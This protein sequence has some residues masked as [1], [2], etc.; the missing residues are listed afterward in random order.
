MTV[1]P[2]PPKRLLHE[3]AKP[4]VRFS[5]NEERILEKWDAERTFEKSLAASASQQPYSFYDGPPFATGLPHYGNLLAGVLKD[6]VPRYWTMRGFHVTRRFGW[7]CHGLPVEYE[8]SKKLKIESNKQILEMGIERY[9]AECRGIVQRYTQ[10][11]KTSVRRIGRWVDM[12]NPYFTMD[13]SF[14]ESVWWVFRQLWDK[15]LVYEG[16]KVLPYSTGVSTPL[17]NFEANLNYK[18]VQDPAV[19]VAFHTT[20]GAFALL[21]WTTTPWTLPSNLALAVHRDLSY[22]K[23]RDKASGKVYVLASAL[24]EKYFAADA[25]ETLATLTGADLLGTTYRPLFPYFASTPNAFRVIH[26][27]HVT[28]EAGTGLVHMAPAFGEED[29]VA[30][31]KHGI[32]IVNPVD[33]DGMFTAEVPDFV[34][35]RVKDA[36]R[37]IIQKLKEQG[38]LIRHETITHSYPFCWRSNTPLI[39]RAV[40]TWFIRVEAVKEQILAGNRETTWV[41][42][43]LRDGRFGKWLENARDWAVSRNRFWGTPLP[44]WRNDQGETLCIGSI[45]ELEKRTGQRVT[46]LHLDAVAKLEIPSATGGSPLRQYGGVLDCWFESGSMPYAQWGYPKTNKAEFE[47]SFPADFIAEGLDQTRGWFYT[48]TVIGNAL[49]GKSPFKNVVVNGLL[50]AEDGKKMSKSLRNYPDPQVLF[51]EHGAD[52]LR[53]YLVDSPAVKAQEVQFSEKGVRDVVRKILLRWWNAYSFYISY[54]NIEA[55]EPRGPVERSPNV[56]D[57]WILSRLN[58][59]IENTNREMEAYK[60]YNVVPNLLA[61]IEDLT[62]TYIRFNRKHFWADGMP[63]DKRQAFETLFHVLHTLAKVMAPFTPFLSEVT[64]GNL[65]RVL[66][67]PKESVHL[68]MYP[69]ADASRIDRSLEDAVARMS[70]M[71]VMA[72]NIR[73][74]LG[75]KAK[76]PLT[77]L[78][79]IHRER[80]VLDAMQQLEDCFIEE[81]NVGRVVYEDREDDWVQISAKANFKKLGARLGKKMKPV[82]NAVQKLTVA[83]IVALESGQTLEL[84]GEPITLDDVEIRR[85]PKDA[86]EALASD[87]LI[88]IALDPTVTEAQIREGVS[89]EVIRRIQVARK[90]AQLNLDD[91]IALELACDADVRAAV[92]THAAAIRDATLAT[93]LTLVD[94]PAGSFV[95]DAEIDG[96]K[97]TIGLRV[98]AA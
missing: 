59:L 44:I 36:D 19:T 25:I 54:A 5:A 16:Y 73:E 23:V 85:A 61:F 91:R 39:Y 32:P 42:D 76:I 1:D 6:I 78:T 7:D 84:E 43:Y 88:S 62:N 77:R 89:R 75:V 93:A 57:R 70:Q 27:D 74:T 2:P 10:E 65:V 17:S 21:A 55:F 86:N 79:I 49:F 34:G 66:A 92:E 38:N 35:R 13:P 67:E 33:D 96:Q 20:D 80:R 45:D 18:E 48:L 87:Q 90:N 56:L 98:V 12:E 46:D 64:Y 24:V 47:A 29:F 50:L 37:D 9:N 8:I 15:G 95:E 14:M 58:S 31:Q 11:W 3:P 82:A 51:D 60:L 41:P 28:I 4:D 53:L 68:E 69:V 94:A 81:I 71:V 83:D 63:D 26:A 30:C 40:S 97:L 52:A 22:A 72:R